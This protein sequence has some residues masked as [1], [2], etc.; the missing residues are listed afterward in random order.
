MTPHTE[1]TINDYLAA[2]SSGDPTPGGG[3]ASAYTG[4]M[5]TALVGMV[6][7]LT[8]SGEDPDLRQI[9]VTIGERAEALTSQLRDCA[10]VDEGVYGAY[11]SAA[12]L[13]KS[14]DD[15]KVVRRRAI[16][17]ALIAA[18]EAPIQAARSAN[19]GL[20]LAAECAAVGTKHAL[21]D[22]R[23]AQHLLNASL[24]GALENVHI[25]L[26]MLSDDKVVE[27]LIRAVQAVQAETGAANQ[28][29]AEALANRAS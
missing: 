18:A 19:E 7:N 20:R 26:A 5:G 29:L 14:N 28:A 3:S 16:N 23:T 2:L 15:E 9:L 25:N 6:A 8:K 22:I 13:P 27:R 12:A 11:R 21:S 4:A 24:A 10:I 17:L 1:R